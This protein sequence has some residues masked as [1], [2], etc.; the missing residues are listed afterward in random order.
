MPQPSTPLNRETSFAMKGEGAGLR[1]L[2]L[3]V[4]NKQFAFR[5]EQD[6]VVLAIA[7][8]HDL[9]T[10]VVPHIRIDHQSLELDQPDQ[11][12][13]DWLDGEGNVRLQHAIQTLAVRHHI[14]SES[15]AVSLGGDYCVTRIST[16]TLEHV[17]QELEALASRIPRYLQLGPGE[18]LTG[19]VRETLQPGID[20]SLTAVGNHN[21]L[22]ALYQAFAACDV[23]VAWIEPS[24]VS[25]ARLV[26]QLGIDE[27]TPILIADSFGRSWE[28][29]ISHQG[30]LLL[31]YRP[32]AAHDSATF[33]K[34]IDHHLA[35]LRRFCL[36]HRG[37]D[38]SELSDLYVGGPS[39]KIAPV[40]EH[41]STQRASDS[42]ALRATP[43]RLPATFLTVEVDPEIESDT[44]A[45]VAAI[46]PLIQTSVQQQPPDLLQTIRQDA[47]QSKWTWMVLTWW[48][49]VAAAMMLATIYLWV[50][51][52]QKEAE[53]KRQE[54]CF[55][56]T[57]MRDTRVRMA[58]LQS[59]R[60][61]VEHLETI[62]RK[63]ISPPMSELVQQITQCLP[64]RSSLD[65]IR[66]EAEREILLSGKTREESEI[67]EIVNYLRRLPKI[68]QVALLGTMIGS[69]QNESQ[70]NIR[71]SWTAVVADDEALKSVQESLDE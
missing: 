1:K 70:F 22:Q 50:G 59:D 36:R 29:G 9:T 25:I 57:Q 65:S 38:Q 66:L 26:G 16:G 7:E 17:D 15:V 64:S 3:G 32:A 30:R 23:N 41:F 20:H 52:L 48:P 12:S 10:T 47:Q 35:R 67:Y 40:I 39:Q 21:R 54:R 43:L 19:Q 63:T 14:G 68:S 37:M 24:L 8:T 46:L 28:V 45:G 71:L 56:E 69:D 5:V 60:R 53:Q 27:D 49:A 34:A 18:K 33:A 6:R 2:K 44:I 42:N 61:W 31:D 58:A 13:S 4:A 62:N 55:V 11:K 51:G